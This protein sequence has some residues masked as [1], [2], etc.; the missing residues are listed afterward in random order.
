MVAAY[1]LLKAT[2]VKLPIFRIISPLLYF[3][4]TVS[5]EGLIM[6]ALM[7]CVESLLHYFG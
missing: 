7:K 6:N 2:L 4:L 3:L 1:F 5:R